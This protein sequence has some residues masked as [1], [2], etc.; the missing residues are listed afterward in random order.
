MAD[1]IQYKA[2]CGPHPFDVAEWDDLGGEMISMKHRQEFN[3]AADRLLRERGEPVGFKG[4]RLHFGN[5]EN[6]R[7]SK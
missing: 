1:N 2:P 6:R 3:D 4:G 7:K 5:P